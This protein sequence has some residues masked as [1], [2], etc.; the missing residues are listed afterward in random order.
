MK[1]WAYGDSFTAGDGTKIAPDWT[2]PNPGKK[3]FWLDYITEFYKA[4]KTI[5]RGI[6]G[7]SNNLIFLRLL[8][9]LNYF[10]KG[11]LV[12]VGQ[13]YGEREEFWMDNIYK[14]DFKN[15]QHVAWWYSKVQPVGS[16][17]DSL[18]FD[19]L[20]NKK[21]FI[22]EIKPRLAE[23]VFASLLSHIGNTKVPLL[24]YYESYYKLKFELILNHLTSLGINT[25][26]WDV[27]EQATKY[28]TIWAAT[29]GKINDG[30]WS[31]KGSEMFGRWLTKQ[32]KIK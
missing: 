16:P 5:N 24:S 13:S 9:D 4:E 17:S 28:Q 19:S 30:H 32:I 6:G 10:E 20:I 11:D 2:C 1:I 29:N 27:P 7:L 15:E 14:E 8:S 12:I 3:K 25:F 23:E 26:L 21:E 22:D 31:W 18:F